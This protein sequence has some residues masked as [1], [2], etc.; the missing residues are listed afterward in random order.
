[1]TA[2]ISERTD[3]LQPRRFH[4]SR[5]GRDAPRRIDHRLV[6]SWLVVRH[7]P[8]LTRTRLVRSDEQHRELLASRRE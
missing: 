7:P 2:P 4:R 6:N 3:L 1:M 8:T 5:F